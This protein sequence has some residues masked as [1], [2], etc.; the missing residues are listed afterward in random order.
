MS[1]LGDTVQVA[2]MMMISDRK[3]DQRFLANRFRRVMHSLYYIDWAFNKTR[4]PSTRILKNWI[5]DNYEL[6]QF[7]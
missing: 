5:T 2:Y 6:S 7:F 4:K 1:R 3:S